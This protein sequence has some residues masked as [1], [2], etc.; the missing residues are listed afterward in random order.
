MK[1]A[2]NQENRENVINMYLCGNSITSIHNS[3]GISRTTLYDWINT[4]NS[5]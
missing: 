4:Y 1:Q 5:N 3:T 2:Y